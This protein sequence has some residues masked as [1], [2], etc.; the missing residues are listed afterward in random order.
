MVRFL[1]VYES[2]IT[3]Y[4]NINME[5]VSFVS[6]MSE[7]TGIQFQLSSGKVVRCS[8][9]LSDAAGVKRVRQ[10]M[11]SRMMELLNSSPTTSVFTL[12][13]QLPITLTNGEESAQAEFNSITFA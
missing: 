6:I 1:A 8:L 5:D 4:I 7:N 10:Y 13:K 9:N 2:S 12:P 3:E 11:Q